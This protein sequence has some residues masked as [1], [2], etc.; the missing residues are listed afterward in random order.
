[1]RAL[2][3]QSADGQYEHTTTAMHHTCVALGL[4][5]ALHKGILDFLFWRQ[6]LR[7]R[8]SFCKLRAA[9]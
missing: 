7:S 2:P 9:A 1:M 4:F 5:Q 3:T 8:H 6:E